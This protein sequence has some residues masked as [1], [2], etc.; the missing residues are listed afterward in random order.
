MFTVKNNSVNNFHAVL[1]FYGGVRHHRLGL[2]ISLQANC[3][4]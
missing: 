3:Y 1:V 4:I 2:V